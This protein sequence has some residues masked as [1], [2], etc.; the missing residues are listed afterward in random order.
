VENL[1]QTGVVAGAQAAAKLT[2][3]V[4]RVA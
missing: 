1:V 4:E 2:E 3:R